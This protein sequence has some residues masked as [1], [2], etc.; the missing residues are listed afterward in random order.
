MNKEAVMF[1]KGDESLKMN[2]AEKKDLNR[3]LEV[4][5]GRHDETSGRKVVHE[6]VEETVEKVESH[7]VGIAPQRIKEYEIKKPEEKEPSLLKMISNK[8]RGNA[9]S[10]RSTSTDDLLCQPSNNKTSSSN[11]SKL[12]EVTNNKK[13][14]NKSTSMEQIQIQQTI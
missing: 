1:T 12:K 13:V 2:I 6:E 4:A 8:I 3:E 10:S 5:D 14:I 9:N 7:N 11:D